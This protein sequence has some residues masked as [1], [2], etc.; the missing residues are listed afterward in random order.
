MKNL[1]LK[2]YLNASADKTF[3]GKIAQHGKNIHFEYD[4]AFIDT[5]IELSPFHLPL[6]HGIQTEKQRVFGGIHGVFNDSLPDGWG[7][8]LMDRY[9]RKINIDP[10]SASPLERLAYIGNRAFGA[11]SYKPCHEIEYQWNNSLNL[12]ILAA[13]CEKILHGKDNDI[14][15]E[16]V[17]AGG[18]PG[19][20]RP[21]VAVDYNE[22][23]KNLTVNN[24]NLSSGYKSF[25]VKFA[26]M[27]DIN[28]IP[29]VEYA[30]SLM[31]KDCGIDMPLTKLLDAGRFGKAFGIE[32]LINIKANLS[33]CTPFVVCCM[34]IIGSQIWT[35]LII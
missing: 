25:L 3:V 22:K 35:I 6:Q 8:L 14:L 29:E 31:A 10:F 11:L 16:L 21:K 4:S 32:R 2:V 24:E 12:E 17:I 7:T 33:I 5:G 26:T 34:Q 28:D 1:Q 15:P 20:A 27:I 30:Y 18:S 23:T 19:G 9:F 13:D